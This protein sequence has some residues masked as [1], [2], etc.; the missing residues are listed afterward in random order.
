MT[1]EGEVLDYEFAA[2][3]DLYFSAVTINL[4]YLLYRP[5][6]LAYRHMLHAFHIIL[7]QQKSAPPIRCF[8]ALT[9]CALQI[10]FTITITMK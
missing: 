10:V 9:L 6:P 4:L 1:I 2:P 7:Q 3:S 5:R 8:Y